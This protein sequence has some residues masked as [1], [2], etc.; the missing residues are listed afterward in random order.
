MTKPRYAV[1][2][3]KLGFARFDSTGR[4]TCVFV[5]TCL[6]MCKKFD[7]EKERHLFHSSYKLWEVKISESVKP[8]KRKFSTYQG[9]IILFY[10][11]WY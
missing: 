11:L 6:C 5:F 8:I 1:S 9:Q 3:R 7:V 4:N 2:E 10:N